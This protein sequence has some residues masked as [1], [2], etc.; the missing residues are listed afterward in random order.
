VPSV[1]AAV[2]GRQVNPGQSKLNNAIAWMLVGVVAL[3]PLPIGS[4]RPALWM[5]WAV[6]I[7]VTAAIYSL[8]VAF[9]Q[10]TPR[11]RLSAIWPEV[12][13]FIALFG[14]LVFQMLPLSGL[15]PLHVQL[16]DGGQLSAATGSLDPDSTYLQVLVFV[17]LGLFYLLVQQVA[18]NRRR[19]R[20]MLLAIFVIVVAMAVFGLVSL[21]YLGDTILGF[22]K[23]YYLGDATGTFIH[24]GSFALFLGMGFAIG[25]PLL[26]ATFSDH[27]RRQVQRLL[28]GTLVTCGQALILAAVL[29]TSSRWGALSTLIGGAVGFILS[30]MIMPTTRR[31]KL[32]LTAAGALLFAVMGTQYANNVVVRMVTTPAD[33]GRDALYHQVW[34]AIMLRPWQ[35]YGAGSFAGVFPVFERAPLRGDL[36]WDR[37]HS[38]YLSLWFELGVL[39]G[40]IPIAI[41]AMSLARTIWTLR[42]PPNTM[43]AVAGISASV[44]FAVACLIDISGEMLANQLLF[45]AILA[46]GIGRAGSDRTSAEEPSHA[47]V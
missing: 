38:A 42:A 16:P 9:S 36:Y 10:G 2:S 44:V 45:V 21:T 40:S 39:A 12:L 17:T 30:V 41:V 11:I 19:A 43:L 8:G 24:R 22:E 20:R 13:L 15:M 5:V 6:A 26:V 23:R 14:F 31:A 27:S 33:V 7:G 29:S 34:E 1:V 46:L 28:A 18:V 32:S 3:A 25:M 35:G 4:N 37:A 47:S